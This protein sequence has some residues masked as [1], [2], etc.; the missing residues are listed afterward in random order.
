[1]VILKEEVWL[2]IADKHDFL[3]PVCI[4]VRLKR[5]L[6]W[7]DLKGCVV[8]LDALMGIH[9]LITSSP[10]EILTMFQEYQALMSLEAPLLSQKSEGLKEKPR[11]ASKRKEINKK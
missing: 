8:N 10:Q 4:E 3:C 9:Y 5:K 1:M 7:N 2:S 6:T 11:N